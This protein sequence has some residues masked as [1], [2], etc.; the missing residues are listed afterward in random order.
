MASVEKRGKGYR[1]RSSDG[2]DPKTGK[3]RFIEET[4]IPPDN[5]TEL[6][7]EKEIIRKKVLFEEKCRRQGKLDQHMTFSEF[8]DYWNEH[9]ASNNLKSTTHSQYNLL[10]KRI[11]PAFGHLR[12]EQI[13]PEHINAFMDMLRQDG[14]RVDGVYVCR[15]DFKQ[16]SRTTTSVNKSSAMQWKSASNQCSS[17]KRSPS[18]SP[19][20]RCFITFGC[21]GQCLKKRLN[22]ILCTTIRATVLTRQS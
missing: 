13:G 20:K 16:F 19:Q 10:L 11:L 18:R 22:G 9:Y 15:V 6:Q 5:M 8:A 17:P 14:V 2:F 1:F 21:C 3:R 12:M 7:I 4:W